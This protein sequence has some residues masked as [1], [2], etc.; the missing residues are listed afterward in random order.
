MFKFLVLAFTIVYSSIA[1]SASVSGAADATVVE[2]LSLA[3]T[4]NISFGS[5]DV[6]TVGG[7]VVLAEDGSRTVTGDVIAITSG[8]GSAGVFTIQGAAAQSYSMSISDG[9]ISDGVNTMT[10]TTF[11]YTAPALTGGVDSFNVGASLN[12]NANQ[13]AG[14]YDTVNAGGTPV[15]V[16]ANYN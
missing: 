2:P 7:T 8:A 11:V 10:V 14:V 4:S 15:N 12:V 1:F 6:S 13:P 3:Q 9:V 16:T 5:I